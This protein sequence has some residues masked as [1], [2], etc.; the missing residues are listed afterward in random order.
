MINNLFNLQEPQRRLT[1]LHRGYRLHKV[2]RQLHL[3]PRLLR[4]G[5]RY[6]GRRLARS[7]LQPEEGSWQPESPQSSAP[8]RPRRA[9]QSRV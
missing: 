2:R 5:L 8:D 6:S 7:L 3:S 9:S 1:M 4:P